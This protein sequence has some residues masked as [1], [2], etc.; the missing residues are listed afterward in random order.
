M[1]TLMNDIKKILI[2]KDALA[3]RIA[4]L[5]KQITRDYQGKEVVLV[6]ILKGAMPFLCDLMRHID[7]PL[8]IDTMVLSSYGDCT[9]SSGKVC[10]KKSMVIPVSII[11]ST[12]ITC[13]S[14][15][16]LS[17]SFLIHTFPDDVVQSP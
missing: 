10:I 3:A 14:L 9:T 11:S 5:G 4:A 17:K 6:G 16:S 15:I 7:L 13:L 12:T 2:T 1:A 8:V